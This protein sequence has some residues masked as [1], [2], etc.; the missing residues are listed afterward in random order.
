M[1]THSIMWPVQPC[2]S[3]RKIFQK[4]Q[5]GEGSEKVNKAGKNEASLLESFHS[6][7]QKLVAQP[8]PGLDLFAVK[9]PHHSRMD[10]LYHSTSLL[11]CT[12][13]QTGRFAFSFRDDKS[14]AQCPH[15][16]SICRLVRLPRVPS[17]DPAACSSC[18]TEN[19]CPGCF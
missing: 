7:G 12:T 3:G 9:M 2:A 13:K 4:V 17:A 1:Q 19:H 6:T 14:H 16:T 15:S 18:Q 8:V 11:L 5:H 10:F